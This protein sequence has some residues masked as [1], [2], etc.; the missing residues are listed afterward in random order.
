MKLK[1]IISAICSAALFIGCMP[2]FAQ[3]QTEDDSQTFYCLSAN[4][5]NEKDKKL[6]KEKGIDLINLDTGAEYTWQSG[7][8]SLI[9][10]A[11]NN[12]FGENKNG[13]GNEMQSGQLDNFSGDTT[14]NGTWA[15]HESNGILLY[16]LKDV[17]WVSRADLWSLSRETAQI[18]NMT[19]RIGETPENMKNVSTVS[20]PRP[21]KIG[22]DSTLTYASCTF[23]PS[24][25]R[26]VEISFRI[27]PLQNGFQQ[28]VPAEMVVFGTKEKPEEG[29]SAGAE[30]E[31]EDEGEERLIK[32]EENPVL[33]EYDNIIIPLGE[34][35]CVT[36]VEVEYMQSGK[37]DLESFDV[38]LSDTGETY[39]QIG[40]A[41]SV[42]KTRFGQQRLTYEMP[43]KTY[44]EYVKIKAVSS[45]G[46]EA[47]I[48][49]INVYGKNGREQIN[50]IGDDTTYRYFNQNPYRTQSD[51]RVADSGC[52]KLTDG[53]EENWV[54]T[55][56]E[57]ATV[58]FDLG[59]PY[60]IG[61]IDI[62]SLSDGNT[63]MEGCEIRYSYDDKKYF[64]YG[65][66]VN[67]NKKN[68][69]EIVKM[70]ASGLPGKNARYIK[71]IAQSSTG[72]IALSEIRIKGYNVMQKKTEELQR[73]PLRVDVMKTAI[74][75]IDWSTYNP[76][77]VSKYALY[78][79]KED[80]SN[81]SG[82][83]P[84]K[85]IESFDAEFKNRYTKHTVLEPETDYYVAVT[86]F[87]EYGNERKDVKTTKITTTP[88]IGDRPVDIFNIVHHPNYGEVSIAESRYGGQWENMHAEVVRLMDDIG[89]VGKTRGWRNDIGSKLFAEAGITSMTQ[90][91]FNLANS[92]AYGNYLFSTGNEPDGALANTTQFYQDVLKQY[93]LLKAYDK[94]FVLC[95]P[96]AGNLGWIE[97]FYKAG[98]PDTKDAFDV[99]D[100]HIYMQ[101]TREV[102]EG[103]PKSVPEG[104]FKQITDI[105]NLMTKYGDGDKPIIATEVGYATGE[106]PGYQVILNYDQH[107]DY[108]VR[109]YLCLLMLGV[110]EAWY[111]NFQDDGMD[112]YNT[113][114]N[115]GLID[116][117]G[118]PKPAYY[119][120]YNLA[121]QMRY[122][123]YIGA[124]Q[125]L[126]NPYYGCVFFDESKEK[127]IS[128]AWAANNQEKVMN[129]E[130]LSGE[131]E[132]IDVIG[133]DGSFTSV[134]T[135]GGKGSV[136]ISG[137]PVY[138]YSKE[139]VKA[140]EMSVPF[141]CDNTDIYALRGDD[142]TLTIKRTE[143]GQGI[144]GRI[145]TKNL[146]S[147][148]SMT[149]DTSFTEEDD[150][151][152][153]NLHIGEDAAET[154]Q[155][156]KLVIKG[157]NGI[158]NLISVKSVISPAVS[159]DIS[160]KPVEFG[161][162]D[163]WYAVCR[164]TNLVNI[165]VDVSMA[166]S[167][168][169]G[170][171]IDSMETQ[172]IKGLKPGETQEIDIPITRI[173]NT[174]GSKATFVMM[175]NGGKY[176]I[177]R[178]MDFSACINDGKAPVLDGVLSEG[179]WDN[180][181]VVTPSKNP[182][183]D[184]NITFKV[185]RKWDDEN[186]YIAADVT[187]NIHYQEWLGSEMW[188]GD[189][190]QF[191]I[192]LQRKNGIAVANTDY[193]EIGVCMGDNN[194]VNTWAWYAQLIT[195]VNTPV[196]GLKG[197]VMRTEDNHTIY[198]FSI[199]WN[200]LYLTETVPQDG[201]C[202]GFAFS[203]N[204]N[205]GGERA[206]IDYMDGITSKKAPA[207]F[208]DMV[209]IKR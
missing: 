101:S 17:Y 188:K 111:Y 25:A 36:K 187:D 41:E 7:T 155:S 87:D 21:D 22:T 144:S 18:K 179:E 137:A 99:F 121:N 56:N 105:R 86:P 53:D 170:I 83:T 197:K 160:F 3:Q 9:I 178:S 161:K 150:E 142:I 168:G 94:K 43:Y 104:Q 59:Q 71:I 72:E 130:T 55:N 118:V 81:V 125:G 27:A 120:Y 93:Q 169:E 2:V 84:V 185:Y 5:W 6:Y 78:V 156:F 184:E 177:E 106:L 10:E 136:K 201:T 147:G 66:F 129:F 196:G 109:T 89:V 198:E 76:A 202:I 163:K 64:T 69:G 192:D 195:K 173:N 189:S 103:L 32:S 33:S 164:L 127:Y 209:L 11:D 166:I 193:Y 149:N 207:L 73:V 68:A 157:S 100:T 12:H 44:S 107:R 153:V 15:A 138:L 194:S 28:V 34:N 4:Q 91:W 131:D 200:W 20:V 114:N 119:G 117:L 96:V 139:G 154:E 141:V 48:S 52:K 143:S 26:Y 112:L 75:Y 176:N 77:K 159:Y 162:W 47:Q 30:E 23:A 140:T 148:W 208:E 186:L 102:P 123:K 49:K 90:N 61:D 181:D 92:K 180:C 13:S 115:W 108:I 82:K 182:Y 190:L 205:D 158:D 29:D 54:K 134:R 151:I 97:S 80:F 58:V 146:P 19:V 38:Y 57:W 116:Y 183:P 8:D 133:S 45:D 24:R 113:E 124:M 62:Y 152:K 79:E 60:Q 31:D 126:G 74:C 135:E 65:F 165:P 171:S 191:A 128:A 132:I 175:A 122:T 145:E 1:R 98:Y 85:V 70:T 16:D 37:A 206:M 51:I 40:T 35:S 39:A 172:E 174:Q 204:D 46:K 95:D 88:V 110:R 199:P 203:I 50:L 63:F 42:N 167:G 67:R 14:T